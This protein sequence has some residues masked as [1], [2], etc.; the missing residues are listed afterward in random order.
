MIKA[1]SDMSKQTSN[2][3]YTII[4]SVG[5]FIHTVALLF[6]VGLMPYTLYAGYQLYDAFSPLSGS[7]AGS[8][9]YPGARFIACVLLLYAMWRLRQE[10]LRMR[11]VKP[12]EL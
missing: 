10:G 5:V 9:V 1:A 7:Q 12:H 11:N 4:Q 2:S 3:R 6:L 8:V